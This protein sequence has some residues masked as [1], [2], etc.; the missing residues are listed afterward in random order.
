[1]LFYFHENE[2]LRDHAAPRVRGAASQPAHGLTVTT[3]H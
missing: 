2:I 3:D 1:L